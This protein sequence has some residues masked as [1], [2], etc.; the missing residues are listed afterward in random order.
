MVLELRD[1]HHQV[2]RDDRDFVLDHHRDGRLGGRRILRVEEAHA[3]GDQLAAWT[4]LGPDPLHDG[5]DAR[6]LHER[7]AKRKGPIKPTL[8]DQGLLA[9]VGYIQATEAL[10]FA[11]IDP[12][13][14]SSSLD[15]RE[16]GAVARGVLRSIRET[17]AGQE[18][19]EGLRYLGDGAD[20]ENP[21]HVYGRDGEPCPRCKAPLRRIVQAARTTTL[22]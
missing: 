17:L 20:V 1:V 18:G 22:L 10:F 13:R 5:I 11:R 21:F 2:A 6:A 15:R 12:R 14:A 9:G 16:V 4:E 8:L 3:R 19:S 7:L